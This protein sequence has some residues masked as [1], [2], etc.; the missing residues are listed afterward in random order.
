MY[1]A[2]MSATWQGR[3]HMAN[4]RTMPERKEENIYSKRRK[5]G[6]LECTQKQPEP[7]V[8]AAFQDES[9]L[10]LPAR[11]TGACRVIME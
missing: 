10:I 3:E 4:V 2:W 7:E 6:A 1:S 9:V 8:A 5:S 11:P